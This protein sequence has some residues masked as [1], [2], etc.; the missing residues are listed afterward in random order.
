MTPQSKNGC[1]LEGDFTTTMK[2]IKH[3]TFMSFGS[4]K[5]TDG[6]QVLTTIAMQ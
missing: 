3:F 1:L 2:L 5:K 4:A 6:N